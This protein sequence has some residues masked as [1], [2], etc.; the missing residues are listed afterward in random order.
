VHKAL[1]AVVSTAVYGAID[2]DA[3]YLVVFN[4]VDAVFGLDKFLIE[5]QR[6]GSVQDDET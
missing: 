2:A 3:V 4:A 1:D 6:A 5:A